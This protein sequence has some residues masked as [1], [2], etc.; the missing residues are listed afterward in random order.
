MNRVSS[1]PDLVPVRNVLLSAFDKSGLERL[2]HGIQTSAAEPRFY[3]TGGTYRRLAELLGNSAALQS[4]EA[5]T[6]QPE[7]QGG[8]VK[9]LDFK[10]YLGLLSEPLNSAHDSDLARTGAVRFDLV[11]CN[12]YPFEQVVKE[13]A[14]LEAARK[15]IDIGGPTMIRAAAKNFHRV[16]VVSS[17]GQYDGITEELQ[18]YDG[19]LSLRT[20]YRLASEAFEYIAQYDRAIADHLVEQKSEHLDTLYN[21]QMSE[22]QSG[23]RKQST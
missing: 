1:I 14:D 15:N 9:S 21:A 3:A 17:P 13:G 20:R 5:Y 4:I 12:L 2:V 16:A 10:I 18:R 8:L 6:G 11:V 23:Q 22:D 19:S 7:M